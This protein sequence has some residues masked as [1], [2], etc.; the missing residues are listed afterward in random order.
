MKD[1]SAKAICTPEQSRAL[2]FSWVHLRDQGGWESEFSNE[3]KKSITGSPTE[4]ETPNASKHLHI[5]QYQS[6]R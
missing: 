6:T 1:V 5:T 3:R 4:K 2:F